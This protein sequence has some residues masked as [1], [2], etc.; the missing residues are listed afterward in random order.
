M[1]HGSLAL[2]LDESASKFPDR[3]ALV[4]EDWTLTYRELHE[5]SSRLAGLLVTR[6]VRVGDRVAL[7]CPN[8]PWFTIAY[9]AILKIGAVVVP[10]N[11]LLKA[12]DVASTSIS[13]VRR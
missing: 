5:S 1:T 10:L 3:T 9:F 8:T 4:H 13:W 2:V 7:S 12:S 6:G 11:V